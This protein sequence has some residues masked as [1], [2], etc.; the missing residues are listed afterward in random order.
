LKKK[1][2]GQKIEAPREREPSKV[3]S[4]M[5]ALRRSVETDRKGERRK[6]ARTAANARAPKKAG[7]S[8]ARSRTIAAD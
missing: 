4:L 1:Q 3:I 5:D 2:S 7:R 6:P 8:S